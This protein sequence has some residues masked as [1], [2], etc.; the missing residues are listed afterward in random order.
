MPVLITGATGVVGRALAARLLAEGGQVRAYLRR[1]DA[2]LRAAGAHVA[3]GETCAVE[4][5]ESAATQVHTLVHLV[6]GAWPPPG[7]SYDLLNRESAECAAI[8]ARAAGVRR[9]IML[10]TPGAD[11]DSPNPFLAS[12]GAAERHVIEAG[13]EHAI[14]RTTP[15]AETLP[16]LFARTTGRVG[17]TAIPRGST[18]P[19]ALADVV[20]A[21][22]A[23]DAREA[24]V[25]GVYDLMGP[26]ELT[27]REVLRRWPPEGRSGGVVG[28]L[29][30]ELAEALADPPLDEA[31]RFGPAR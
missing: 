18:R 1:D 15:I 9:I 25:R 26:E 5:L 17:A 6:G 10:S 14:F 2:A 3:L 29:P 11:P 8:A 12:R 13:C 16:R 27:W 20:E 24:E 4:R 28:R 22:V 23:A 30:R 7:S 31:R 21:I 19:V